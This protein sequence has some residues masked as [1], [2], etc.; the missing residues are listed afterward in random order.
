MN[1]RLAALL[2]VLAAAVAVL[3]ALGTWQVI[4]LR[5]AQAADARREARLAAPPLP[6]RDTTALDPDAADFRRVTVTGTWD[7]AHTMVIAN[8]A[9]YDVLGREAVTP[10]LPD[11]GGPA[12]LVNRGWF[13][14]NRRDEVLA[15][16]A[17]ERTAT[18][19]GLARD[20][21]HLLPGR[22]L[23]S[24]EW[25]RLDPTVM[26]AELPY[27]VVGWQLVQGR[28]WTPADDRMRPASFPVQRYV[29]AAPPT[30]HLDYAL[31][32]YGLA[33]ALIATAII[34]LRRGGPSLTK[35]QV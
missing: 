32:W 35:E 19:E 33:I 22:Q 20:Y 29:V 28:Q 16:L 5:E 21:A 9:Q 12:V 8:R 4:R 24:G 7:H 11:G 18:V 25:T 10:L 6:W 30:P 2:A 1:V 26:A 17:A 31:T 27:P 15:A 3:L 14:D 34:R 23:P 13:P